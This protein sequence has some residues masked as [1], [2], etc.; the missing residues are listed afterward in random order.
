MPHAL[1]ISHPV[2]YILAFALILTVT[3]TDGL[4]QSSVSS[5][6]RK[7]QNIEKEIKTRSEKQST[8]EKQAEQL[9]VQ[10]KKLQLNMIFMAEQIR[11]NE[12]NQQALS[13]KLTG[14]V[15]TEA[16]LLERLQTDRVKLAESLAALQRFEKTTPPALTV[17]PD[18]ALSGIRGALAMA[19]IVPSLK[20]RADE[21]KHQ[22]D[23]LTFIR[24]SIREQ[25]TE[26]AR[27]KMKADRDRETL[28]ALIDQ[29]TQ[30]E[31]QVEKAAEN[32][33]QEIAKLARQA[34]SMRDLITRLET[35]RRLSSRISGFANARGKLP[36][37]V[38][39]TFLDARNTAL[40][41][42]ENGREGAYIVTGQ[43]SIVTA[44][45]DA[46]V[47]YAGPFRD[48]GNMFILG[49]GKNYHML[50]AGLGRLT[51]EVGQTV[52]AGEPLGQMLIDPLSPGQ[53]TLYMEIRYKGK[54][55]GTRSWFRKR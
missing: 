28:A 51:T 17:R 13:E 19:S 44:P 40:K 26:L 35:R 7:L 23:E 29:K 27:A 45:H 49:V 5:N 21:I 4:G 9:A 16:G 20:N 24:S 42:Q 1:K 30:A 43:N 12:R 8:L 33:K 22:L 31:V 14:L 54:P 15:T 52:L 39:G 41:N 2:I 53:Q 47:L 34:S 10:K 11:A 55:A 6:K 36:W 38:S 46:Q 18:D 48:Y 37:P 32:E 3:P 25:Q 50:L